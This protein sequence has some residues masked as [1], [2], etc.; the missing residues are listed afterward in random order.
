MGRG[1]PRKHGPVRRIGF[2]LPYDV[3]LEMEQARNG[4]PWAEFFTD[5]FNF[6]KEH[7]K[8]SQIQEV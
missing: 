4:Q 3:Y 5:L 2:E 6:A 7:G 8:F 1:R